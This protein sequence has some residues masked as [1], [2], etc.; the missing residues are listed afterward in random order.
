MEQG[1][2]SLFGQ[3]IATAGL[4]TYTHSATAQT[5]LLLVAISESMTTATAQIKI[6]LPLLWT[7]PGI[8]SLSGEIIATTMMIYTHSATVQTALL[9]AVISVSMTIVAT[10]SKG[11]LL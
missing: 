4:V 7:M 11:L 6:F 1:I 5:V 2:L 10:K 9:L 8:L 3:I